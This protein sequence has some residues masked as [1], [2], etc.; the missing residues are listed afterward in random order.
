VHDFVPNESGSS[1]LEDRIEYELPAGAAGRLLAGSSIREDLER[2]F[3]YQHRIL[4]E[5]LRLHEGF[6]DRPRLRVA[7]TGASGLIGSALAD[8]LT[9]GGHEVVRLSRNPSKPGEFLWN[10]AGGELDTG[11]LDGVDAVVHLAGENVAARRWTTAQMEKIWSSRI[12]GT[13]WLID[14]LGKMTARPST[15]LC[16]SAIGIYGSRGEER[17]CEAAHPGD[18]F[19]ANVGFSWEA[20]A[21]AAREIGMRA[22]VARFGVVLSP[23]G[24]ALAKMLPVFRAGL[25]GRIGSG[26]Q[27]MSW[28]SIEDAAA[29]ILQVLM[30]DSLEG[31]VNVSAP[32][33]VSNREFTDTLADVL[34]R[35]AVLPVPAVAAR[36]VFGE[37]AN[38]MLLASALVVPERLEDHGFAFRHPTLE[39]ALRQLLGHE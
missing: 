3:R 26:R 6:A 38:E 1:F 14:R 31:A 29:A 19:L 20:E 11:S 35:P 27:M 32:R 18:G 34:R 22:A 10:P 8:L 36:T 17:L 4:G 33:P 5:D 15:F 7:I 21:M 23:R 39:P 16:A 28:V 37:M 24:G 12:A 30:D 2:T 13:R 9:T 25:G